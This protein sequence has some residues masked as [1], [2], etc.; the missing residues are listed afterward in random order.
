MTADLHCDTISRL[1]GQ[2]TEQ[3]RENRFQLDL[4]RMKNSGY[5]LQNFAV[6]I[7]TDEEPQP[8]KA[9]C[10]MRNLFLAEMKRNSDLIRQVTT[11][12]EIETNRKNGRM[13]ALLTLE[14]GA[15][16]SSIE[17]LGQLFEDGVRMITLTWNHKNKIGCPNCIRPDG[18]VSLQLPNTEDGL[19]E[20][21]IDYVREM[22]RLGIA[23]DVS[24]LSDQGFYDVYQITR[25]P[26]LASHSNSRSVKNHVRNLTDD[27]IK[28][29]S[30]R[31]GIIG[32]NFET[33]FLN[34]DG[35]TGIQAVLHHAEHI[36]KFGGIDC[37]ALGSDF[38]G[39]IQNPELTGAESMPKLYEG[40]IHAGW[41]SKMTEAVFYRN[42][43]R[44]YN[45]CF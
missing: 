41:S 18:T 1:R 39:I 37:L 25:R 5:I 43:L 27:M 32:L 4:I 45:E 11:A 13:S 14:E 10:E 20:Y 17:Q 16:I 6:Y 33:T 22:E 26:F 34:H 42:L 38:D 30:E 12:D 2:A 40:F 8:Y 29:I 7:D 21:G 44:Y 19:T 3:L 23:V 35:N 9:Y 31:G 24:H 15:A 36:M 28:K